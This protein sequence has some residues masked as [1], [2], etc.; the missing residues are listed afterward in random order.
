MEYDPYC[1]C[2]ADE[3]KV[4]KH[5]H[6]ITQIHTCVCLHLWCIE[7]QQPALYEWYLGGRISFR[8]S[9]RHVRL[10]L[11]HSWLRSG[12]IEDRMALAASFP[13]SVWRSRTLSRTSIQRRLLKMLFGKRVNILNLCNK[14]R[15][16]L[17]Y[18]D[19]GRFGIRDIL[20]LVWIVFNV[21]RTIEYALSML[22]FPNVGWIPIGNKS[23]K[24]TWIHPVR[25]V[26]IFWAG[27]WLSNLAATTSFWHRFTG[28]TMQWSKHRDT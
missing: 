17:H 6:T 4:Q 10:T 13:A 5:T 9:N 27:K 15:P 22:K 12:V 14:E 18:K 24:N 16:T 21:S 7:K 1:M 11:R 8:I 2:K 28:G 3:K 19:P 20:F 25:D 26:A 23:E